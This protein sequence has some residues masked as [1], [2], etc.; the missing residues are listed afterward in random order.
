MIVLAKRLDVTYTVPQPHAKSRL[1][2]FVIK[3][4]RDVDHEEFDPRMRMLPK[5][6]ETW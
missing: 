5:H 2:E 1:P 6:L 4:Q 3:G